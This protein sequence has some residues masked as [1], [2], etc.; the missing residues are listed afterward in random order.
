MTT[1]PRDTSSSIA[2][3]IGAAGLAFVAYAS[4]IVTCFLLGSWG[5][6]YQQGQ[7]VGE[8]K[9]FTAHLAGL[10]HPGSP[11]LHQ[12]PAETLPSER[13]PTA[14][15]LARGLTTW[16]HIVRRPFPSLNLI[17]RCSIR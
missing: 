11:L 7:C 13:R 12:L 4:T 6:M 5:S 16:Q 1:D 15:R 8:V 2:A 10:L 9:C 17:K 14:L 3:G